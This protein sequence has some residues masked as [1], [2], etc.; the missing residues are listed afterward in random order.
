L[1]SIIETIKG[2]HNNK[3][4]CEISLELDPGTFNKDKLNEFKGLCGVTRISMGVQT[5]NENE[6]N[7]LGR[8]HTF[9]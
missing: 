4:A 5:F 3:E 8:G 1:K 2:G 9:K 6:F 7:E